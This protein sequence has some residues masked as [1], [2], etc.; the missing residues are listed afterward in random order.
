MSTTVAADLIESVNKVTKTVT[1]TLGNINSAVAKS[2]QEFEEWKD[3]IRANNIEGESLYITEVYVDGDKDT[4]YPVIFRMPDS[5]ETT[6]EI[7]RHY[8]W[9]S[10]GS[11]F[12]ATHVASALV[13]L[14]GQSYPWSGDAN[15]LRTIVNY[16][17]YRKC[18]GHVAFSAWA[19]VEKK[20]QLGPDSVYNKP[21]TGFTC[22]SL[23]S[24][25][26]RGG[27]L[28]YNIYSNHP[29]EFRLLKDGELIYEHGSQK[30]NVKYLA[31]T[32]ILEDFISGDS[33][34]NHGTTYIGY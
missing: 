27:K 6:I 8:A 3:S 30:V 12:N 32:V 22:R 34:N 16:Q 1:E 11:D 7:Y 5:K 24:F 25:M 23:S 14:K 19:K 20:D 28:K 9:N 33:N 21:Q 18:V 13:I 31:K 2:S 10:E 15:Y 4:F 29:I 17:R 26:L